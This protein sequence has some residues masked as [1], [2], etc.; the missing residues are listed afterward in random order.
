[1]LPDPL[2]SE[3]ISPHLL[4]ELLEN[5]YDLLLI[6]CRELDE[7][8]FNRIE[9][10]RHVPLSQF[11]DAARA[12]VNAPDQSMVIYCHHGIRSL[13]ATRWLRHHG[14]ATVFSMQGG[15]AAW[16]AEIDPLVPTY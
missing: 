7:W 15:I 1:M 11:P 6:D 12:L 16:S 3:E 13:H 2:N 9:G 14:C 5:N 8:H 10:A 4:S